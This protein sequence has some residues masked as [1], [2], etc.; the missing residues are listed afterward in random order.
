MSESQQLKR[1][2]KRP[3]FLAAAKGRSC[4]QGA[5]MVQMLERADGSAHIGEGF[6]ATRKIGGAV[7]RNRAKRRLREAA[8]RLL[9]ELGRPGC[10]YVFVARMGTAGRPWDRLLDDV[11]TALIRLARDPAEPQT[12]RPGPPEPS[13]T[14]PS[15]I[16]R[17][18]P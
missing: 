16:S 6:T 11:K 18:R 1:L 15:P 7:V 9:P 13:S 14:A 5:V 17:K 12:P 2:K 3:Q 4:A 8:R 10:D